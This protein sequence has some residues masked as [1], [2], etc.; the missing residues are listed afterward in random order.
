MKQC[1]P[2][3]ILHKK[4]KQN[5]QLNKIACYLIPNS[6]EIYKVTLVDKEYKE[7]FTFYIF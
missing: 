1:R 7:R 3:L 2:G 4:N 6:Q 5:K